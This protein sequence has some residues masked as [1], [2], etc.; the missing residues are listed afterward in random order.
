M[1]HFHA[2]FYFCSRFT[3]RQ[4]LLLQK[5]CI[6]EHPKPQYFLRA[7]V[8][9][10][11]MHLYGA[12]ASA[13]GSRCNLLRENDSF[14]QHILSYN[15]CSFCSLCLLFSS[16]LPS[17]VRLSECFFAFFCNIQSSSNSY[18]L[19]PSITSLRFNFP[20]SAPSFYFSVMI[21]IILYNMS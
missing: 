3:F 10:A 21:L 14:Y 16:L 15:S 11:R 8:N 7:S 17:S 20:T 4:I 5:E 9:A 1:D 6:R 19:F 18:T 13:S 2:P 12:K